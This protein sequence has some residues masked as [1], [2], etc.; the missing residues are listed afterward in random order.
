VAAIKERR[1]RKAEKE[2]LEQI[3]AKMSAK[4][5]QR[6]KKVS[7]MVEREAE[8]D[9][10]PEVHP[11][12]GMLA[13]CAPWLSGVWVSVKGVLWLCEAVAWECSLVLEWALRRRIQHPVTLAVHR[14][15]PCPAAWRCSRLASAWSHCPHLHPQK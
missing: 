6:L 3:A 15:V 5:L 2:R 4:K 12:A 14:A 8:C 1:E 11:S 13:G 10:C 9:G 7:V